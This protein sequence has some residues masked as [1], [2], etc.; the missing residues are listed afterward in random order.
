MSFQS[1]T[2]SIVTACAIRTLLVLNFVSRSKCELHHFCCLLLCLL[3]QEVKLATEAS[4]IIA[5]GR[6]DLNLSTPSDLD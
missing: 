6:Q 4:P 5:S 2:M 3:L 1:D